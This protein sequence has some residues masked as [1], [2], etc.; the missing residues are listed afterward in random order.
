[1]QVFNSLF[2]AVVNANKEELVGIF[3]PALVFYGLVQSCF[4][5][6][7]NFGRAILWYKYTEVGSIGQVLA[8]LGINLPDGPDI[9]DPVII[10]GLVGK[11]SQDVELSAFIL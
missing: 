11:G 8:Q 6:F 5:Y 1:L 10:D 2:S 3:N 7:H 9:P 4:P